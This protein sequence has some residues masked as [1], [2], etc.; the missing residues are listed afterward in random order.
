MRADGITMPAGRAAAA[1]LLD[2]YPD[3]DGIVCVNDMLAVGVLQELR[4]RGRRVPQDVQLI[5]FDDQ[6]LMEVIGLSTIKQPMTEFGA[7]AA[8]AISALLTRPA[9][10]AAPPAIV[11][12]ELPVTLIPR[13]TTRAVTGQARAAP[14]KVP[15]A[16]RKEKP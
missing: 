7:W 4:A 3:I 11:S 12:A 13:A 2:H 8:V 10:H 1:A 9:P 14:P 6:P 16:P 15:K 5:G